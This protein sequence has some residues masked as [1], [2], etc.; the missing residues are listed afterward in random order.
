MNLFVDT[1]LDTLACIIATMSPTFVRYIFAIWIFIVHS[2]WIIIAFTTGTCWSKQVFGYLLINQNNLWAFLLL[3]CVR[4]SYFFLCCN[5]TLTRSSILFASDSS[6]KNGLLCS[7][8]LQADCECEKTGTISNF[9]S[10][11]GRTWSSST[12]DDIL[13]LANLFFRFCVNI[14]C[15]SAI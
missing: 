7:F 4:V 5:L 10:D 14:C 1:M 6:E 3:V 12:S 8:A 11:S 2:A 9:W 15:G 13:T